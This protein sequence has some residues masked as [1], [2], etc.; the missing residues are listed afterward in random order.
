MK[1]ELGRNYFDKS[2]KVVWN[3]ETVLNSH[4]MVI[5]TSG[6]GKTYQLCRI[7][8]HLKQSEGMRVHVFDVHGDIHTSPEHTSS[9]KFSESSEY[10]VNPFQVSPDPDFGGVRKRVN[11]FLAMI[12]RYSKTKLGEKQKNI[13]RH[14]LYDLYALHGFYYTKPDTW[15]KGNKR[16]PTMSDLKRFAEQK[17]KDLMFGDSG[18]VQIK[19]QALS[20]K[21]PKYIKVTQ[22]K[23]ADEGDNERVEKL[24][25]ELKDAFCSF[26][27]NYN[28]SS[29]LKQFLKYD[30]KD[31]LKSTLQRI[32]NLCNSGVFKDKPPHFISKRP[33]WRYDIKALSALEMGFVVELYLEKIFHLCK[34]K[35]ISDLPHTCV[36]LD[37]AQNFIS[38]EPDHIINVIMREGRKFGLALIFASQNFNAFTEDLI[39]NSGT[40]L[41]LGQD[42]YQIDVTSKKFGVPVKRLKA[43]QPQKTGLVQFKSKNG[44]GGNGNYL[45]VILNS[46]GA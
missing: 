6:S 31:V 18:E 40:K 15:R 8:D 22:K 41:L 32:E 43:I 26:I 35:G 25:A 16:F 39:I 23:K 24:K 42:H 38:D 11:L 45:S 7:I 34:E 27:D 33:I 46:R 20:R 2:E 36:V 5:G 13:L 29:Q 28:A 17:Y 30:S 21:L 19:L 1:I 10:G 12:Q 44:A 37:E 9:V 4:W 14:L 3:S